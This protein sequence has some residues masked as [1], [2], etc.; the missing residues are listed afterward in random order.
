MLLVSLNTTGL[1]DGNTA[2][3]LRLLA[4][5]EATVIDVNTRLDANA[6]GLRTHAEVEALLARMDLVITT[7]MHG[8]ILA[9]KHGIPVI[10]I[11]PEAGGAQVVRQASVVGWPVVITSA[12]LTEVALQKAF[13]DCLTDE[14]RAKAQECRV[15]AES[16][17]LTL[18]DEFPGAMRRPEVETSS[19]DDSHVVRSDRNRIG[20]EPPSQ[21]GIII[22]EQP[23]TTSGVGLRHLT[24][25][26]LVIPARRALMTLRRA[27]GIVAA[28]SPLPR[29]VTP[30]SRTWGY[31]RGSPVDR[32][33]IETFLGRHT[34][35]IR[36]RV[37]E[38]GDSSYTKR[39]GGDRVETSEI[40]DVSEGNPEATYVADLS[41]A[42]HLPSDR[43]DC[44]IFTQTLH[45][46]YNV[47]AAI[48]ALRRLLKPGGVLLATFPGITKI[49]Q[50]EWGGS[51]YWG[52][53][54]NSA[55]R[56]FG[57]VFTPPGVVIESFGNVLTASAFLYGFAQEELSRG[58]LDHRDPEYEVIITARAEKFMESA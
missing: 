51:W 33:Y 32:Y 1:A 28:A 16:S 18:R 52:F 11:D 6:T 23:T 19:F 2:V 12:A 15:R 37:L 26:V 10:A 25:G 43:F 55:R 53:S 5:R 57:D 22:K 35:D 9:L 36:G 7:Q 44:I 13:D 41:N 21:G 20:V 50:H 8:M 56:L 38:V 17:L 39:F 45:L 58:E 3:V 54:G 30:V 34:R 24:E 27:W 29:R 40:L 42:G 46:I 4:S 31:D 49:S 47:P 14:V 48:Q